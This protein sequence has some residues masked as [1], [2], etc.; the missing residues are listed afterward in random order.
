M[1]IRPAYVVIVVVAA[2]GAFV[3]YAALVMEKNHF[4]MYG[5]IEIIKVA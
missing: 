3:L 1:R 2:I 5:F 4:G